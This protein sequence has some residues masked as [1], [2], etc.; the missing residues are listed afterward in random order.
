MGLVLSFLPINVSNTIRLFQ[1]V[2][3]P[4]WW[5]ARKY[6]DD[7][8]PH[9][10][11]KP[12]KW[13]ILSSPM[14]ILQ[15]RLEICS[16]IFHNGSCMPSPIAEDHWVQNSLTKVGIIFQKISRIESLTSQKFPLSWDLDAIHDS[17]HAKP[18]ELFLA[19]TFSPWL[20]SDDAIRQPHEWKTG[21]SRVRCEGHVSSCDET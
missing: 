13:I 7:Q 21:H 3:H 5:R 16:H 15:L 8:P 17:R 12:L 20:I 6:A 9:D 2:L 14:S 19:D 4:K 10:C 18:N 11:L 1:G